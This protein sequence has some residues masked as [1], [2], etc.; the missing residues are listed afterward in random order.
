[1]MALK[2]GRVR[3]TH[4]K[5]N[6]MKATERRAKKVPVQH[7]ATCMASFDLAAPTDPIY[8]FLYSR[9]AWL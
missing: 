9:I 1:M 8:I 4:S 3:I 5:T 6:M 7:Y 2:Y